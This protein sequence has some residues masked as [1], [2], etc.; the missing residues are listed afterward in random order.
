[1]SVDVTTFHNDNSRDG[2]NLQET[3]LT[4]SN[5]N[6]A[7][8]G[9]VGNL[10]TDGKVDAQPLYLSNVAIPGQ[11]TH[12]VVYVA[13]E[14]DSVYAFDAA[15]GQVLW[16][17]GPSGTPTTSLPAGYTALQAKDFPSAAITGTEL[18]M[19]DTPVIDPTTNTLYVVAASESQVNGTPTAHDE[20]LAID[21]TTGAIKAS[22]WIDQSITYPGQNPV[23]NGST[24]TFQPIYQKERVALTLVNGVVYTG[25]TALVFGP[26]YTG[27]LIGFNAGDLSVA[28][29]L[30]INPNGVPA[31]HSPD[32][33]SGSDFWNSGDGLAA[34][35]AGNLFDTTSNG[36]FDA[37]LGDFGDSFLK[38]STANNATKVADY[39]TPYDQ[40]SLADLDI[41]FGSSGVLL[42]P[43]MT[44]ASGNTLQLAISGSKGGN[45]YVVNRNSLGGNGTT[46]N[47]NYQTI[48]NG[49]GAA[50]ADSP[51]YYNGTVYFGAL[52]Q[53]MTAWS[54][55]NGVLSSAPTS[56]TP[57]KFVYPGTSPSISAD[58]N[59]NGIVWAVNNSTTNAVLYAYDA[60]NLANELY[61]SN[62]AANGRDAFGP[63]S[64]FITP[65]IANGRVYVGTP[66]GVAVFGLLSS[67]MTPPP[68]PPPSPIGGPPVTPPPP[69]VVIPAYSSPNPVVGGLDLL[70]AVGADLYYGNSSLT[71]TWS[72]ISAPA[73]APAPTFSANGTT[74]SNFIAFGVQT[75]GT[76]TFQVAMTDPGGLVTTSDV[77]ETIG[78][79][80]PS[81]LVPAFT[82]AP[83]LHA[84]KPALLGVV[85]ADPV[86]GEQSLT[87]T[88]VPLAGPSKGV[89]PTFSSQETNG[90]KLVG[91]KFPKPGIY[92]IRVSIEN[93]A[94]QVVDNNLVV[95]VGP[96]VAA[97]K[98]APP[99][100][101]SK[102]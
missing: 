97:K 15:S 79:S 51:A 7:D 48:N 71:Y 44:D 68:P 42:L 74:S 81:V 91:V 33:T 41:D 76:Y 58:G 61:D 94:G 21:T 82:S 14:N 99:K 35:A 60:S 46:G 26:P 53:A 89:T 12:D 38:L 5:V 67:T 78:L 29:V 45:I 66:T 63:D 101:P 85:G 62:Q 47:Y 72:T 24:L 98:A 73:S 49:L 30:N 22:H 11:G 87:Y 59:T 37:S 2:A 13:T 43:D 54:F 92:A 55:T 64:T 17:D 69:T 36:P 28:S 10:V 4:P 96:A 102:K 3:T 77:T 90:S 56:S 83:P 19:L 52:G 16:H 8:F 6:S 40:Q 86:Y 95:S 75:P 1:M 32:L 57:G 84:G 18:G 27:W 31:S 20:I 50:E 80:T 88:W 25:W 39:F 34:D 70:G 65:M 100:R 9:R 23:G 93:P